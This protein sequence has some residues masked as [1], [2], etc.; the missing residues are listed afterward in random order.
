MN[1]CYS[2][3]E[4]RANPSAPA[5]LLPDAG[6][7]MLSRLNI[8][9]R[10]HNSAFMGIAVYLIDMCPVAWKEGD[11]CNPV[12]VE[13]SDMKVLCNIRMLR[14]YQTKLPSKFKEKYSDNEL[15]EAV[16]TFYYYIIGLYKKLVECKEEQTVLCNSLS[17]WHEGGGYE[18][19]SIYPKVLGNDI[20][21]YIKEKTSKLEEEAKEVVG[22]DIYARVTRNHVNIPG[23]ELSAMSVALSSENWIDRM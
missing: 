23:S 17:T 10:E 15:K 20:K 14:E 4:F 3:K 13:G 2:D 19:I 16:A 11:T 22:E 1:I 5:E 6:C 21:K 9:D 12:Y 8:K 7:F 18:L